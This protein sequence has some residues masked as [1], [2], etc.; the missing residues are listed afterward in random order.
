MEFVAIL[1]VVVGCVGSA[2]VGMRAGY[3]TGY[4]KGG[5][6][7]IELATDPANLARIVVHA[8]TCPGCGPALKAEMTRQRVFGEPVEHPDV[9]TGQYL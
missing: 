5:E 6:K 7:G 8:E 3:K 1:A 2:Y 9:K 4:L